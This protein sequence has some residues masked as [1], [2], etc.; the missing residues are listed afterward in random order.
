MQRRGRTL[1]SSATCTSATELWLPGRP[2]G[3]CTVPVHDGSAREGNAMGIDDTIGNT[4]EELRGKA[5]E[6]AGKATDDEELEA[7][8]RTDQAKAN[9]KQ[10]GQK[11]KKAFG[12]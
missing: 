11:V 1:P 10:A 9:L 8:G 6:G 4:A 2:W 3:R 7:E 5:K 12:S